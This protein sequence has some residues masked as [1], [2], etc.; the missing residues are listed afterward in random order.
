MHLVYT[1]NRIIS[2]CLHDL[3]RQHW[4]ICCNIYVDTDE[5]GIR[6]EF[7]RDMIK[8]KMNF[9]FKF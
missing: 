3:S 2:H 4:S 6:H 1:Y 9:A 8:M 5:T 7:Y